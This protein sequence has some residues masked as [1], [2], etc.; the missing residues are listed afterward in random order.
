MNLLMVKALSMTATGFKQSSNRGLGC[1]YQS[2][3]GAD[4]AS[5]V[6]MVNDRLGFGCT[7]FGVKHGGVS[8]LREFFLAAAAAQQTNTILTIDLA[9]GEIAL[10]WASIILAIGIDTG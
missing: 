10:S 7:H 2:R 5:F 6:E 4:T 3:S 1:F 9:N 8:S